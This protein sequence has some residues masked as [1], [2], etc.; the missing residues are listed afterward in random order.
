[1]YRNVVT[2]MSR[3]RNGSDR[4]GQA[5]TA[6]SKSPVPGER[7]VEQIETI[8]LVLE[9]KAQRYSFLFRPCIEGSAAKWLPTAVP[10]VDTSSLTDFNFSE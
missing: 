1:M 5:L 9:M 3:D 7:E 4:I 2:A 8:S 6:R 10:S